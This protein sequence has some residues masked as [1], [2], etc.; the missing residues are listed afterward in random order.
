MDYRI[1]QFIHDS[2]GKFGV[3]IN[4]TNN[5]LTV[6]PIYDDY[7]EKRVRNYEELLKSLVRL[8]YD[9]DV[10]IDYGCCGAHDFWDVYIGETKVAESHEYLEFTLYILPQCKYYEQLLK[11]LKEPIY[12]NIYHFYNRS[13]IG[14]FFYRYFKDV[15]S[16][17]M[18]IFMTDKEYIDEL[19]EKNRELIHKEILFH[20]AIRENLLDLI[21]SVEV[22]ETGYFA[23]NWF[24]KFSQ[25]EFIEFQENY[26]F[27][28]GKTYNDYIQTLNKIQDLKEEVLERYKYL[29]EEQVKSYINEFI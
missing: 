9:G 27:M 22:P 16:F 12:N 13:F 8:A 23:M 10:K 29:N 21:R 20:K 6:F 15:Y 28:N 18:G 26:K 19:V 24:Q 11:D 14:A 5:S 17:A 25:E 2:K 3:S 1:Q 7:D 4:E